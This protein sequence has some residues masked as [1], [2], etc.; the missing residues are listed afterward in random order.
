MGRPTPVTHGTLVRQ[1]NA[2]GLSFT[3]TVHAAGS[4]LPPHAHDRAALTLFLS[5]AGIEAFDDVEVDCRP[6]TVLFKPAGRVHRNVYG[7]APTRSF[8]L[9]FDEPDAV[10]EIVTR[11]GGAAAARA[12]ALYHA[13]LA[14]DATLPLDA[15]ELL[16]DLLQSPATTA[17]CGDRA[18]PWLRRVR[19]RLASSLPGPI[20]RLAHLADEAGV[21]PIYLARAFR[22]QYGTSLG[23][24][25][26][27]ARLDRAVN[28]ILCGREP[29]SHVAARFGY[30]DQSH[31]TRE[32]VRRSAWSPARLRRAA[33]RIVQDSH[34]LA[35]KV[36]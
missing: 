33:V 21:H 14:G 29:L 7:P 3:E 34:S 32:L 36:S 28:A 5:G 1:A 35:G 18:A 15:D 24:F 10:R 13:C 4:R 2:A 6:F 31:L 22:R 16:C 9:E 12:L 27:R 30:A 20:P 11:V 17:R 26:R 25:A 23:K 8:I 19:D